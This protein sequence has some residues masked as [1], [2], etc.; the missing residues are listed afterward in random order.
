MKDSSTLAVMTYVKEGVW[1][2]KEHQEYLEKLDIH[3]LKWKRLKNY[4]N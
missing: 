4:S 1:K 2:E 3:S